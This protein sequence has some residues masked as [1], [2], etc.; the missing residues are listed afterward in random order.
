MTGYCE[1]TDVERALQERDLSGAVAPSRVRPAIEGISDWLR[2]RSGQHWYDSAAQ[3]SDL[4]DT[5]AR[6]VSDVRLDV[7]SGPHASDRQIHRHEQGV[8]YPVTHAGPYCKV[9]LPRAHVQGIDTLLV[10]E[11]GGGVEDWTA[12]SDKVEGRGEDYYVL[13]DGESHYGRSYLYV[14][15]ASIG[16]RTDFE[17]LLTVDLSFGLDAQDESW[18]DVRRG[19]ALLAGAQVVVDDDVLT[20]IP[21]NGQLVGVDTQRQQLLDDGLDALGP[22][23]RSPIA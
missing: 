2:R 9:P 16:S 12:A 23:L 1:A 11:R 10:R 15:A 13:T 22:Y 4:V 14:R 18:R 8:R 21:D 17:E 5:T 7:P 19:V 6:S 20:A 3:D